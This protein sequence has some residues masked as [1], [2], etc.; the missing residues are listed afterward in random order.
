[1]AITWQLVS[2]NKSGTGIS[3]TVQEGIDDVYVPDVGIYS[4]DVFHKT[5]GKDKI[6]QNLKEKIN[7]DRTKKSQ[8]DAIKAT[9]DMSGFEAFLNS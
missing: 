4:S 9:I 7:A 8:Q 3:A 6:L 2:V 5:H 1:M